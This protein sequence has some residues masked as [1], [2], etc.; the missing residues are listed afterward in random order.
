VVRREEDPAKALGVRRMR[1]KGR[2]KDVV[3][4]LLYWCLDAYRRI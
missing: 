2:G 1:R 4:T 3:D